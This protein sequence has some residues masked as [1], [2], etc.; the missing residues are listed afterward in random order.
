MMTE[1]TGRGPYTGK[2]FDERN[3][4]RRA[5]YVKDADYREKANVAARHGYRDA[6]GTAPPP[7]PT[8]NM[9]MLNFGDTCVGKVRNI[10]GRE[11]RAV[12]TFSKAELAQAFERPTKQVQQWAAG[13]D[14]RIP[15]PVHK[16]RVIGEE[17]VWL[18]VYTAPEAR[19]ILSSLAP[20]LK[21]LL[22][23]RQDHKEAI[24]ACR[25]AVA[26]ARRHA[27]L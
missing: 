24:D 20:F 2:W 14:T 25:K 4:R 13:S 10:Q 15:S 26:Q 7:D 6:A 5:R 3:A 23:F 12:L 8:G 11:G 22:Y 18:D 17:R 1:E 16:A 21:D 9:H 27:G 19:A